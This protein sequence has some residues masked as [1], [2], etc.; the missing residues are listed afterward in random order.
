MRPLPPHDT[1]QRH[2]LFPDSNYVLC[3]ASPHH[4]MQRL[5]RNFHLVKDTKESDTGQE[6]TAQWAA[7]IRF[8]YRTGFI[9]ATTYSSVA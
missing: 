4:R 2:H 8:S 9:L 6:K 3:I 1:T 5:Y 7:K